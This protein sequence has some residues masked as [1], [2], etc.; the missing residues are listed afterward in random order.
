VI[1]ET[2]Y[3]VKIHNTKINMIC[4]EKRYAFE[5]SL[6]I[7]LNK[8]IRKGTWTTQMAIS[9]IKVYNKYFLQRTGFSYPSLVRKETQGE[10][11]HSCEAKY[12]N[13]KVLRISAMKRKLSDVP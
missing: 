11:P 9:R 2:K 3:V 7:A 5:F 13:F 10:I 1:A 6:A 4:S 12:I 8:P